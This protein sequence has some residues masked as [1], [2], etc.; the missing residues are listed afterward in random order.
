MAKIRLGLMEMAWNEGIW[1]WSY[2]IGFEWRKS[3]LAGLEWI[4]IEEVG[5]CLT[6][7]ARNRGIWVWPRLNLLHSVK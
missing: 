1:F 7:M 4:G 2:L 6:G 3:I 5:F